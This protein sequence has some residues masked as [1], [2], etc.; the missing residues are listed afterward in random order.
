[1]GKVAL[2]LAAALM[3][4]CASAS[5]LRLAQRDIKVLQSALSEVK[6]ASQTDLQRLNSNDQAFI[7]RINELN[8]QLTRARR[9]LDLFC[10]TTKN[11]RFDDLRAA[12]DRMCTVP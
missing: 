8:E 9:K 11:G 1:M 7:A 6:K 2:L 5:D 4:G 10:I 12:G 3:G